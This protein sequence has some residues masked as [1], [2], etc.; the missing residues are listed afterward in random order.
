MP[1]VFSRKLLA[2]YARHKRALPWRDVQDP[3]RI[4]ISEI[5]L[6]QTRVAA[7]TPYYRTFLARFP[8]VR[9]LAGARLDS[10]LRYWAGL[11]YYRRAPHLHRAAK[12]I[13]SRHGGEF[14][15]V[16]ADALALPL[17]YLRHYHPM[18][19]ALRVRARPELY[20]EMNR[21]PKEAIDVKEALR[22]GDLRV[23]EN[24]RLPQGRA[25]TANVRGGSSN[26]S[27]SRVVERGARNRHLRCAR[28]F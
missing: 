2:W 15:Q 13:V 3:Y 23:P 19:A 11:G 22:C 16:H 4:W 10:V 27:R 6:Q 9:Q 24:W 1:P 17:S 8:S 28:D 18:P 20:V 5:M 26:S 25:I 7:V 14:P 21:M 12:Q